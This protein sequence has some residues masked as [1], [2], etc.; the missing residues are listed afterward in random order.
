MRL[1]LMQIELAGQPADA[2]RKA[3][4]AEIDRAA[5]ALPPAEADR[6]I[7]IVTERFPFF[8][9]ESD[10]PKAMAAPA[11]PVAPAATGHHPDLDDPSALAT[12]LGS[13]AAHMSADEKIAVM[14]SLKAA[15]LVERVETPSQTSVAPTA[16]VSSASFGALP[17]APLKTVQSALG[18]GPGDHVDSARLLELAAMLADFANGLDQVVWSTWKAIAPNS[19]IKRIGST[20]VSMSRFVSGDAEVGKAQVKQE[21]ERLRQLTA[22]LTASVNQ[23]GRQFAQRHVEKFAPGEIEQL[24]KMSSGGLLVG[25]EVKC[26]RKYVEL[27]GPM[28]AQAIE[29]E[30]LAA[31]ST[32]A[33]SLMKGR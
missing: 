6:L 26:W 11:A 32:Y 20:K 27:A 2:R 9:M 1:R 22:A 13:F 33:E 5:S 10:A 21:L 8:E 29:R 17:D 30:L 18:H 28:D 16:P 24:A 19:P 3:L 7:A 31:I 25:H 12:R 4:E 14:R 15:G 23:A